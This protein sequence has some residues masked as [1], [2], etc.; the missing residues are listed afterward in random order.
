MWK[1][2]KPVSLKTSVRWSQTTLDIS[3]GLDLFEPAGASKPS[4]YA[5]GSRRSSGMNGLPQSG[6][7]G[8]L[9]TASNRGNFSDNS[10]SE[11]AGVS[12]LVT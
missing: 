10:A 3:R 9:L 8:L 5:D 11:G 7:A 2:F 1:S 12:T 4:S 6:W